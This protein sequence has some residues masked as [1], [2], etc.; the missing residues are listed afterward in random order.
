MKIVD[1]WLRDLVALPAEATVDVVADTLSDVGL[2]CESV[3]RVGATVDGVITARVV[4]TERHADAAKVHR[5]FL[6]IG[7]GTEHH[8]WC[9]AFNMQP[10]DVIPWAT[11]GTEMPDG[12]LIETK[13]IVGI[14]SEGMCCSA[15][16]L[17]LGDDHSGILIL[18]PNTPLGVP[19]GEALGL[20]EETVYDLD[21]LRNRPDA[22]GHVGVARDLAARFGVRFG[23]PSG[24]VVAAGPRRSATVEIVDGDRCPRFTSVV[25][26]GIRVTESP[27]WMK[28]RLAA[29]GMRPINN[30]VDVSNYVM[31]ETNQ[32]NHAYDFDTLG[33]GGF[34]IR[35][36]RDGELMITLDGVERNL[37]SDDL[38]ICDADD[39]PIGIAG[40]MGGQNTEIS[41]STTA[42][43]LETAYFEPIGIMKSVQRL[44]LRSEASARNERGIDPLGVESSVARFVELLRLTCPDLVVHDGFVDA[45]TSS[46]PVA[47]TITVRPARV[48]ALLGREF[49]ADE[50]SSLVTPIGFSCVPD[51]PYLAVTAPSW[52][53][54]CTLEI[55]I[56]EEV[57]RLFGYEN[58]GKTVPKSTQPGGL[59]PIQQ[60]RRRVRDVLL[61]LGVNEAMPHPFLA[62][63]DLER[64]GLS[65]DAV[66][67]VNPLAV[68]DDVLR[69]SLRPGLLKALAF[70]ESHRRTGV[71]LFEIGHVYPPS[72]DLLPAEFEALTVVV[73]GAE[74]PRAVAVW[75]ELASAM[76]WGARLDQSNVPAGLHPTRSAT[77]SAGRDVVGSIGEVHPDVLDAFDVTERVAIL[78][79]NL[80]ILLATD[81]KV[82][83]WKSTSRFPSSDID[84]A[85]NVPS[86]MTAEKVDKALRQAAGALLVSLELFD[87]YRSDP[88]A[89]ARSLA[90]R[91]RLQATDRTLADADIAGVRDKCVAAVSKLGASLRS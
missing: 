83:Q 35:V 70:N 63:G 43:A 56:V 23:A 75:R 25:L 2:A 68:G 6:D 58:L 52:R 19:Y 81:P 64:A 12:R 37:T 21:V 28:S 62:D 39:R 36:A 50:I 54:D 27:D 41:E 7:D 40:I 30:V 15:R 13:P 24:N 88:A 55:D 53:P 74:A 45:R 60:R 16:E 79:L 80:S 29:A 69:T 76:G 8:V 47:P 77:L 73:A 33:G 90:F 72:D 1:S 61:G 78:E 20:A 5:V 85:F 11:P 3:D 48:S 66:R 9:G 51:G 65:T 26:S 59:S 14:P 71:A 34:R 87:V 84:L 82:V 49:T 38:L 18:D 89:E 57:A 4:K 31:L 46:M 10:G 91:L 44:A 17:G 32:P 86:S 67:L 22:F 42:V